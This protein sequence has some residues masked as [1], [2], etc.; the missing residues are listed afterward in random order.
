MNC[1]NDNR[2]HESGN[3]SKERG[4]RSHERG[5]PFQDVV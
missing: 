3:C 2:P 5:N 4:N 1:H